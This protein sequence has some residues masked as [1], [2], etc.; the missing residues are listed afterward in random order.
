[1]DVS[2][3]WRPQFSTPELVRAAGDLLP[4]IHEPSGREAE[5]TEGPRWEIVVSPRVIRVRT[6]DYMG[7]TSSHRPNPARGG[8]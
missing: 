4:S 1:M 5:L 7:R 2:E 6:R 3:L 8:R